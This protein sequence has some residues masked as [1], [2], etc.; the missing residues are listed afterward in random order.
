[1]SRRYGSIELEE[2]EDERV[3]CLRVCYQEEGECK[4]RAVTEQQYIEGYTHFEHPDSLE[5]SLLDHKIRLRASIEF[6]RSTGQYVVAH[7]ISKDAITCYQ[8]M[9]SVLLLREKLIDL[10][11]HHTHI[12]GSLLQVI[13]RKHDFVFLFRYYPAIPLAQLATTPLSSRAHQALT[14]QLWTF[15]SHLR[16]H[17]YES[18][19]TKL[20][21]QHSVKW[22]LERVQYDLHGRL[23]LVD[24]SIAFQEGSAHEMTRSEEK[25]LLLQVRAFLSECKV[26][27][28]SFDTPLQGHP[29]QLS[30][31]F[32]SR[33]G[34]IRLFKAQSH[35][36]SHKALSP[37]TPINPYFNWCRQ[38]TH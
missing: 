30:S 21:Q 27:E 31:V 18:L 4:S 28:K 25:D 9:E 34:F 1:M 33:E 37:F 17:N 8:D 20:T 24:P 2:G 36:P 6:N 13:E 22:L 16:S 5:S 12:Y 26:M 15:I 35:T 19:I 32:L 29:E 10:S 23:T 7:S 3:V 14:Q 11:N 38:L